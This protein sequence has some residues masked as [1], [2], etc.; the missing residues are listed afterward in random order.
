[1][2]SLFVLLW[3][4]NFG[5]KNAVV[6]YSSQNVIALVLTLCLTRNDIKNVMFKSSFKNYYSLLDFSM[7]NL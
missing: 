7:Y 2:F 6:A 1:M 3:V 4:V 5:R